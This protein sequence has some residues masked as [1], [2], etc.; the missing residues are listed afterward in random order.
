MQ[1][2]QSGCLIDYD[3]C[4]RR[5]LIQQVAVSVMN[6]ALSHDLDFVKQLPYLVDARITAT[7]LKGMTGSTGVEPAGLKTAP[8]LSY[9]VLDAA[10]HVA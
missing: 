6:D 3:G 5:R 4:F 7:R 8:T 2:S 10:V 9:V 1:E